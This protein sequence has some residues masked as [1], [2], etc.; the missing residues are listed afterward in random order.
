MAG[1]EW[2]AN[3]NLAVYIEDIE[4]P[5]VALGLIRTGISVIRYLNQHGTP[6]VNSRLT[7]IINDVYAQWLYGQKTWNG[8]NPGNPVR[9]AEFW[10]EWA[11]D[12]FS[13]FV[14]REARKK[15]ARYIAEMRRFW[16]AMSGEKALQVMEILQSFE[17]ELPG[18]RIDTS[19]F[20]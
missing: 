10:R 11:Q 12:F 7:N 9:V 18:L 5:E 3:D 4:H 19:G 14:I 6:P 2:I 8:N 17:N 13:D 20:P 16:A 15:T 1:Q